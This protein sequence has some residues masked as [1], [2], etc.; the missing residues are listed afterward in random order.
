MRK[1]IFFPIQ[2][3]D[4]GRTSVTSVPTAFAQAALETGK[5]L[6]VSCAYDD[7]TWSLSDK[8]RSHIARLLAENTL[9]D[10]LPLHRLLEAGLEHRAG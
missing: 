9:A 5:P 3:P 1:S 10:R 2:C 7:H 8:D 6:T 4:C